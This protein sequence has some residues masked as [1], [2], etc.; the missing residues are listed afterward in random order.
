MPARHAR[1]SRAA[2]R[3][4]LHAPQRQPPSSGA[5][6]RRRARALR[7]LRLMLA[8]S[9][10]VAGTVTLGV[11]GGSGTFALWSASQRLGA[12]AV[13]SGSSGLVIT[14][15][16]I[17]AVNALPG[18]TLRPAEPLTVT[19]TGDVDLAITSATVAVA[20]P[21]EV[22]LRIFVTGL[23]ADCAAIDLARYPALGT[24]PVALPE[25]IVPAGDSMTLCTELTVLPGAVP[26]ST[27]TFDL[28]LD[29]IQATA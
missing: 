15:D 8:T 11:V 27:T 26:G 23:G 24:T 18:E 25:F 6:R 21:D 17:A 29:G 13:T 2:A 9:A 1:P 3:A 14:G 7:R 4:G 20:H 28:V 19:N 5:R 12:G 16:P 22:E 10:A